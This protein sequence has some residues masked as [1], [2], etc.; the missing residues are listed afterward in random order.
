MSIRYH[1]TGGDQPDR[2]LPES[3][4]SRTD[5]VRFVVSAEVGCLLPIF[6]KY[7]NLRG[8]RFR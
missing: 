8:D 4:L 2:L 6:F 5:G 1:Y 3:Y 7:N